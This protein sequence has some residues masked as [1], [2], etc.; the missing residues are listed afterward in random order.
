MADML[1]ARTA[2]RW[3]RRS[4]VTAPRPVRVAIVS[5][6]TPAGCPLAS[7]AADLRAALASAPDFDVSV[8]AVDRDRREYPA[9]VGVVI[10]ADRECDYRLAARRL[11]A[12]GVDIALIEHECGIFGGIH[13]SH[14][15]SLTDELTGLGVPYVV[16]L[17][18]VPARPSPAQARVLSAVCH[19]AAAVTVGSA[20]VMRLAYAHRLAPPGRV[21]VVPHGTPAA[22]ANPDP[23]R[24][25]S[26]WPL[27]A[28][29]VAA[30]IRTALRQPHVTV[31]G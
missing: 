16:T 15:L 23:Q 26:P 11:Y 29:Q 22:L 24:Y 9:E 3:P 31:D 6:Y 8:C 28:S 18:T 14:V 7:C 30:V 4:P 20:T 1:Q 17:H 10:D 27:V 2:R 13:G 5:A 19:A 25:A 12:A 21:V